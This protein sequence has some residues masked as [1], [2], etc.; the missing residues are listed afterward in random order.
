MALLQFHAV[1]SGPK[2]SPLVRRR[3]CGL[4]RLEDAARFMQQRLAICLNL[5]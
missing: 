3:E 2:Q 5:S 4:S 1:L